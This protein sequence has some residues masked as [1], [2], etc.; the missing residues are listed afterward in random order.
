MSNKVPKHPLKLFKHMIYVAKVH[1]RLNKYGQQ[2]WQERCYFHLGRYLFE[3][4]TKTITLLSPTYGGHHKAA[5]I[6]A[7]SQ[8]LEYHK[9][10]S[11]PP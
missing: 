3:T 6:G 7:D 4:N 1:K 11:G 2:G 8:I 5:D 10:I 9:I